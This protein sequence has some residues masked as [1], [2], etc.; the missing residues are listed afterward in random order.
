MS[1]STGPVLATTGIT[2]ANQLVFDDGPPDW[3][4]AAAVALAGGLV[5]GVLSVVESAAPDLAV[6]LAW[7]AF[8]TMLLAPVGGRPSPVER[9][10]TWWDQARQ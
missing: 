4:A 5:A 1:R 9:A 7:V 8:A 10:A 6:G 3:N 2:L